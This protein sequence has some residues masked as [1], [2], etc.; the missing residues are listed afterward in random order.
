MTKPQNRNTHRQQNAKHVK[1]AT[2]GAVENEKALLELKRTV[3]IGCRGVIQILPVSRCKAP[4][5][6]FNP[7]VIVGIPVLACNARLRMPLD[8][9][10]AT[11]VR[12]LRSSF[13]ILLEPRG[14]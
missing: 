11:P 1:R 13:I 9:A 3:L 10:N 4:R 14:A 2:R 6:R 12:S 8:A 5:V 7:V